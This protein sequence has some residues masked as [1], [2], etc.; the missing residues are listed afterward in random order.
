MAKRYKITD[1][2]KYESKRDEYTKYGN[3]HGILGIAVG[4]GMALGNINVVNQPVLT[5]IGGGTIVISALQYLRFRSKVGKCEEKIDE[6]NRVLD[7]KEQMKEI[8]RELED[9]EFEK[10]KRR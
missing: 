5:A 8:E 6:I 7:R 1:L 3:I 10:R 9:I 4:F 2:E